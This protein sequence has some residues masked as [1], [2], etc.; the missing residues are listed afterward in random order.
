M[1]LMP[2]RRISG[3]RKRVIGLWF[4]G[5]G[6]L[7]IAITEWAL[8]MMP[9]VKLRGLPVVSVWINGIWFG[10]AGELIADVAGGVDDGLGVLVGM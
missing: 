2:S 6:T 7:L 4:E 5:I 3:D 9:E 10:D 1:G 8:P